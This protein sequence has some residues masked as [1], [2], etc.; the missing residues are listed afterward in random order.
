MSIQLSPMSAMRLTRVSGPWT[1]RRSAGTSCGLGHGECRSL[2]F[3]STHE[4]RVTVLS[5]QSA[6][7]H[8]LP[9]HV[10]VSRNS[11]SSSVASSA[12][13]GQSMRTD[14]GTSIPNS[15]AIEALTLIRVRELPPRV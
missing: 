3:T 1:T 11:S 13:V 8:T 5:G 9:R 10:R 2:S 7:H 14:I 12:T 6:R 15:A 4:R